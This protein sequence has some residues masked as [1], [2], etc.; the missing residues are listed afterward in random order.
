MSKFSRLILIL[1]VLCCL[2]LSA[3]AK[4]QKIVVTFIGDCTLGGEDRIRDYSFFFDTI[5]KKN[6]YKYFFKKVQ[7]VIAKDD[8]TVAN[9]ECVLSD[10][11][12]G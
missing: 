8:L 3:P 7:S 2:P 5:L 4:N 9:L 10:S 6:G 11:S 1:M 12:S